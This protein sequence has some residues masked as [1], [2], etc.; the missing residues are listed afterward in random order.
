M[1]ALAFA[2]ALT[3]CADVGAAR[4]PIA[5]GVEAPGEA[6]VEASVV[7]LVDARGDL[8]CSG[9]LIGERVVLTAAHCAADSARAEPDVAVVFGPRTDEEGVAILEAR[10]HPDWRGEADADVALL[11][12]AE[13]ASAA[14][15][16]LAPGAAA[17]PPPVSVRLVGYGL[18]AAGADDDDRRRAGDAV[19]TEVT[20]GHVVLG[21][22]PAL[23]CRG[24]SGGPALIGGAV[25]AVISRGDAACETRTRAARVDAVLPFLE[26]TLADWA[27]GARGAGERCLHADHCE[28]GACVEAPDEPAIRYCDAPCA[29][30][31]DCPAAMTCASGRCAY[32]TPTPGAFGGPCASDAECAR[33]ECVD[34]PSFCSVRCVTGRGDCPSG[35][36]CA[37]LGG[38]DFFCVPDPAPAGCAIAPTRRSGAGLLLVLA[39][40]T[41]WRASPSRSSASRT[42]GSRS[43]SRCRALPAR[44]RRRSR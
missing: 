19:T 6:S 27:D 20:P 18:T 32:P 17:A 16:P 15:L 31:A 1:R 26:A 21:A 5:N 14:P 40:L 9:A 39:L 4:A 24:D 38:V 29:A 7:A 30:D 43:G 11:L 10:A 12:L 25:A 13:P 2:V 22:D 42:S 44:S 28:G 41:A 34:D 8:R 35:A 23:A 37:H 3:G 36:S 33:G